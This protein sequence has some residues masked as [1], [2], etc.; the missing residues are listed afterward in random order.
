MIITSQMLH[1]HS[2]SSGCVGRHTSRRGYKLPK[3]LNVSFA[4]R[5]KEQYCRIQYWKVR[6]DSGNIY[7][8]FGQHNN[9][10]KVLERTNILLSFDTT[11]TTQKSTPQQ[12]FIA[13]ETSLSSCYLARIRGYTDTP[14]DSPFTWHGAHR[15]W[16]VQ[17]FFYCCVCIRCRGNVFT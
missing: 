8:V 13:V 7:T 6:N 5:K 2:T 12:F 1:I 17:R 9:K 4:Q 15:K 11:W 3:S 10:Q 14:A 16:R